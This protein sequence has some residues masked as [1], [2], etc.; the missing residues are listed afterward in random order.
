M[1][2]PLRVWVPVQVGGVRQRLIELLGQAR[3]LSS[4]FGMFTPLFASSVTLTVAQGSDIEL[5]RTRANSCEPFTMSDQRPMVAIQ[6]AFHIPPGR[7]HR[8]ARRRPRRAAL[9]PAGRPVRRR[10][11]AGA[12]KG[13]ERW[14]SQRLSHVLGRGDR[15]GRRLCRHR[16][17][18]PALAD[19]RAHRHRRRRPV[20]AGRDGVAAA[21][22]DR[23]QPRR[24]WCPTLATHLGH[25]DAGE[26]KELRQGR[27]YA[28]AAGSPACSPPTPGSGPQLLVDWEND[29]DGDLDP[30]CEWQPP[31]W[32]ALLDRVDADPPHIRHA[33]TL[34]P[35]QE[36]PTD[37]PQRLSLFGHTRLPLTEIELLDALATHHELHLWLPHPSDELWRSLAGRPRRRS[38]AA[39]TPPT[40]TSAIRCWPPS[41]ATCANCSA[42]C[43]PDPQAD[44]YVPVGRPD[45]PDTLL[46][47]LQSD[48]AANAVR[49]RRPDARR[50]RP[51]GAGAQLPRPGPADRRAARGAARLARRRSDAGAARHPRH[52][53]GHRDLRAADRR[54]LRARRRGQRRHPRT[55]CGCKLADR[56]LDPDQSAARRRGATAGPGRRPGHRQRG[57]QPR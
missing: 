9:R 53:P 15:A 51:L 5:N 35:L 46:G 12:G 57:A 11:G 22:R 28:V 31:L 27:R 18:Q 10:T 2:P 34:A 55:G 3:A 8:S 1:S 44:E 43:P 17:P 37:L 39:K 30:T 14:L 47:W 41:A 45:R 36:S 26:E 21:R 19:R 20:V 7:P 38:P 23:R 29:A 32:R 13:V 49:P 25:F 42:A 48:I 16:V 4:Y 50:R 54:G 24:P 52:V 33:K 6:C 40:A 56:A